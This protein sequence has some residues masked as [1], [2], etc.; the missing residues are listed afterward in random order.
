MEVITENN[1]NYYFNRMDKS[2]TLVLTGLNLSDEI[3]F[4]HNKNIKSIHISKY[5]GFSSDNLDI[6]KYFPDT[7]EIFIQNDFDNFAG[8][9]ILR[10]L[11]KINIAYLKN[12]VD[13]NNFPML[14]NLHITWNR[15]WDDFRQ[16][17]KLKELTIW[18]FNPKSKCFTGI[19]FPS[20]LDELTINSSNITSFKDLQYLNLKK[21]EGHYLNKLESLEELIKYNKSIESIILSHCKKIQDFSTLN[22][23]TALK[24]IILSACGSI[25]NIS[26]IDGIQNLEFFSFVGTIIIDGD[27]SY[28]KRLK[29][30]GFDNKKHYN[31]TME[32]MKSINIMYNKL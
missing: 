16:Y 17:A 25:E 13:L 14:E 26:F 31:F 28:C 30:T 32:Q 4:Y 18:N 5:H 29:Y 20:N 15:K 10:K 21:F 27:I 9:Y 2:I 8:I 22:K 1:V 7:E 12:W 11:K 3:D 6:L 23:G 24:K 19:Y